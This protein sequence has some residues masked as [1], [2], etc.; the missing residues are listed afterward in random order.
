MGGRCNFEDK[1]DGKCKSFGRAAQNPPIDFKSVNVQAKFDDFNRRFFGG[2]LPRIP[3]RFKPLKRVS[4]E[5][6]STIKAGLGTTISSLRK[7]ARYGHKVGSRYI[8]WMADITVNEIVFS[9]IHRYDESQFDGILLH[10]MIHAYLALNGFPFEQ[11]S[12]EFM[13]MVRDVERQ[14]GIK[15]PL[16][17]DVGAA[18]I[19]SNEKEVGLLLIEDRLFVL[20]KPSA[21]LAF[22]EK[23]R[24]Y[25]G[26]FKVLRLYT[27]RTKLGA[28]LP[29]KTKPPKIGLPLYKFAPFAE[30]LDIKNAT[31]HYEVVHAPAS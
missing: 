31:M 17:H 29:V 28:A 30:K 6:R 1:H 10:E 19:D 9:T 16:T 12:G 7:A 21:M 8:P 26:S 18:D 2:S 24:S 11:H 15:I 4:G 3:I 22:L 14:S 23:A 25:A 20:F 27:L 5:T 13:R